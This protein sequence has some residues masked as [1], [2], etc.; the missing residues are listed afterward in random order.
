MVWQA[1]GTSSEGRHW[2]AGKRPS[3]AHLSEDHFL[4]GQEVIVESDHKPHESIHLKHLHSSPAHL[5]RM[6]LWLQPYDIVIRYRPGSDVSVADALSRL[7]SEDAACLPEMDVQIHDI[8][9][10]FTGD[11]ITHL[12]T[13]TQQDEELTVLR[14]VIFQ[15]WPD[16][17]GR[18]MGKG[19]QRQNFQLLFF[20][21]FYG[22]F[23]FFF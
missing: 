9:P 13:A 1:D 18:L 12:K 11:I 7:P 6:L 17:R 21:V 19:T 10:Q 4:F 2:G 16:Q 8:H 14:E 22:I 5:R 3:T 15:G 20:H 23:F